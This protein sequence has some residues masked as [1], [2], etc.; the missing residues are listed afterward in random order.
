MKKQWVRILASSLVALFWSS[1][2]WSQNYPHRPVRIIVGFEPGGG[3]DTTARTPANI[4]ARLEGE[5]RKSLAVREVRER[6][7]KV[8][9]NP[10]GTTSAEFKSD[11][12][13]SMKIFSAAAR[14]AGIEP[15]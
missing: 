3:P 11:L 13:R 2:G 1:A 15:E 5:V 6:F 7:Q 4:V 14:L 8:G 12:A 10:L 9:L